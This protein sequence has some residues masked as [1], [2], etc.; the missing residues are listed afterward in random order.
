MI[1]TIA[2]REISTRGRTKAFQ[3]LTGIMF[4]GVVIA[5]ILIS[6]ITGGEDEA[7]EVT[8]GL[9]A[10][11]VVYEAALT[12]ATDELD[13]EVRVLTGS[14]A[15]DEGR[16]LVDDGTL[17]VLFDGA[18]LTWEARSDGT[19]DSFIRGTVQQVEFGSRAEALELTGTDL[20]TLFTDVEIDEVFLDGNPGEQGIRIAAAAVSTIAT[21]MML[22]I[23]GAFLMMGV[24]EEKSSRVVE[25]LLSHVTP[26]T[27]L[28]G[29]I[30]GLGILAV[31]QLLILVA[32][33]GLGLVMVQ[34]IDIPDGVWSSVPLLLVTFVLGYAFYAALF[35]ALGSTVSRQEDAQSVQ[36]PA[37]IPLLVGYAIA[38]SSISNPETLLIT[39]TS[40]IPFTSPIVLPFRV[41]M[42]SPP[43][44]QVG[45]SLAI[46]AVSVPIMLRIAGAIY[47]TSLL[48]VGTRVPLVQAFRNRSADVFD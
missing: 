47:R 41:A 3:I 17:D 25:V 29:K 2:K 45:L 16:A 33:I 18:T 7:K 39:I 28:T 36:L 5:A 11:G 23:W 15:D 20:E 46:L 9:T 40:F 1:W 22:Q 48:K 10:E 31:G 42:T 43:W 13:P 30:L 32:G 35:A 44:W 14:N 4:A 21:F 26:R 37:I 38:L 24:I 8:I 6:V 19:L 12:V 34:D 27:L